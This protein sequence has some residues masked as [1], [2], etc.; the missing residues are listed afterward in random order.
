MRYTIESKRY[1]VRSFVRLCRLLLIVPIK[2]V[3]SLHSA[4][5][6][7]PF[8]NISKLDQYLVNATNVDLA[9]V[10]PDQPDLNR[11][12][13]LLQF[14]DL[15][16]MGVGL[17]YSHSTAPRTP[18]FYMDPS[19]YERTLLWPTLYAFFKVS[20]TSNA[21]SIRFSRKGM[22]SI[23]P[24]MYMMKK[25]NFEIF[26]CAF[27]NSSAVDSGITNA[28]TFSNTL[29]SSLNILFKDTKEDLVAVYAF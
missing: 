17:K 4:D 15:Y 3:V 12:E 18:S 11:L 21:R 5:N 28:H 8:A 27:Y 9:V 6:L 29:T 10:F 1:L 13:Y 16:N 23:F 26:K 25:K 20:S 7:K 24:Y 19:A 22:L 14:S 2:F